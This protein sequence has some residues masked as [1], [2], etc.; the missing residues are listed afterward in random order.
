M[1]LLNHTIYGLRI[2][3][4]RN[5]LAENISIVCVMGLEYFRTNQRIRNVDHNQPSKKCFYIAQGI[6]Y[7]NGMLS[8]IQPSPV[9]IIS[10]VC[11]LVQDLKMMY[12]SKNFCNV[13]V[14]W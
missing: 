6:N 9:N 10:T 14:I 1:V 5:Y 4:N 7:L 2:H 13:D 12:F 11:G 3:D 8:L